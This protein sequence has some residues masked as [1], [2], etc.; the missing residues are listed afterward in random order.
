MKK[1]T[2]RFGLA[3]FFSKTSCFL[4]FF[5]MVSR[6]IPGKTGWKVA[7]A[8]APFACLS[9]C[10]CSPLLVLRGGFTA[11]HIFPHFSLGALTKKGRIQW[12]EGRLRLAKR[13]LFLSRGYR[14]QGADELPEAAGRAAGPGLGEG[15]GGIR[16]CGAVPATKAVPARSC[17]QQAT[18][19]RRRVRKWMY[20]SKKTHSARKPVRSRGKTSESHERGPEGPSTSGSDSYS[21]VF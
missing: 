20:G 7:L 21:W 19:P 1:K 10:V 2:Q 18:C 15:P 14:L 3:T 6:R 8:L 11:G 13:D 12:L 5:S 16:S 17:G 9:F 4:G